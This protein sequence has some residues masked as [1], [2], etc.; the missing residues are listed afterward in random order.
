MAAKRVGRNIG[1][2]GN[3]TCK[4]LWQEGLQ[5][6]VAEGE[7]LPKLMFLGNINNAPGFQALLNW[8]W[9]MVLHICPTSP[10]VFLACRGW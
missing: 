2:G 6:G 9:C 8:A 1:E 3:G 5:V 4:G 7:P 10:G